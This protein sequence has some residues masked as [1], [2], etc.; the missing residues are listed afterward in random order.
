[1]N[2]DWQVVQLLPLLLFFVTA[3]E[4]LILHCH[5]VDI[6]ILPCTGAIE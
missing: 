1:M 2:G 3:E 5:D 4:G 6:S